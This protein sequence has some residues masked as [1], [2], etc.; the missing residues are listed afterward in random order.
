[1]PLDTSANSGAASSITGWLGD[2]ISNVA[3]GYGQGLATRGINTG[4]APGTEQFANPLQPATGSAGQPGTSP[5]VAPS[6]WEQVK[7]FVIGGGILIAL[8]AVYRIATRR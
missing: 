2:I 3:S 7:P 5:K 4:R 1:M 6:V 8:A